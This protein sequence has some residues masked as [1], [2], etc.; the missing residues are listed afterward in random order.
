MGK[1]REFWLKSL[2]KKKSISWVYKENINI[3]Q[4]K[5]CNFVILMD[6]IKLNHVFSKP[7]RTLAA[8]LHKKTLKTRDSH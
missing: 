8:F 5:L 6:V 2:K 4:I 7:L 3:K 1:G